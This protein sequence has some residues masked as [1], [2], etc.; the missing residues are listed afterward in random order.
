MCARLARRLKRRT[1]RKPPDPGEHGAE[2]R[3]PRG[4]GVAS[5]RVAGAPALITQFARLRLYFPYSHSRYAYCS[6]GWASRAGLRGVRRAGMVQ[7][8]CQPARGGALGRG[9]VSAP[10]RAPWPP[11]APLDP[12]PRLS[13]SP[14]GQRAF[15]AAGV[16]SAPLGSLVDRAVSASPPIRTIL[17][18][19][20]NGRLRI[21]RGGGRERG[22]G[23]T[24]HFVPAPSFGKVQSGF[25]RF[26]M[27][28]ARHAAETRIP[29]P[30][31]SARSPAVRRSSPQ[32]LL[33]TIRHISA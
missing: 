8:W 32:P 4:P 16:W 26:G 13:I 21:C 28:N 18:A 22:Q 6:S 20:V 15:Q 7:P 30:E 17:G 33:W 1:R 2:P 3:G 29:R 11:T 24:G 9:L 31:R 5:R 23:A 10:H 12:P 19:Q 27:I 14:E 25:P